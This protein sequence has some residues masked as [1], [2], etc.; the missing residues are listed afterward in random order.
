[1]ITLSRILTLATATVATTALAFGPKEE[2][3][4][5]LKKMLPVAERAF[6]KEDIEFFKKASTPDFTYTDVSGK[7]EKKAGA[8]AGLKTMFDSSSNIKVKM[9]YSGLTAGGN[10]GKIHTVQKWSMDTK[11]PDGKPAKMS[12]TMKTDE[13]FKKVGNKWLLHK[14]VEK[15]MSDMK[16]NG[17]PMGA[18]PAPPQR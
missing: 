2:L 14:I 11:G 17:K 15:G 16:M 3:D 18:P 5:Y 9:A 7:T 6:A 13:T 4:A 12:M 8:M 10:M 1:M